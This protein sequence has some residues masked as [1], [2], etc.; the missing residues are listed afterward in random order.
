MFHEKLDFLMK[1]THSSNSTLGKAVSLDASYISRLRNGSRKLP[2]DP[3]F[4]P[5]MVDYFAR[6]ITTEEQKRILATVPTFPYHYEDDSNHLNQLLSHWLLQDTDDMEE[7]VETFLRR[8][9]LLRH[10]AD[11]AAPKLRPALSRSKANYYFG[12]KGKQEAVLRFLHQVTREKFTQTLLLFSSEDMSWLTNDPLFTKQWADLMTT[13]I[14]KGNHIRIIHT[15]SRALNEIFEA[16]TQWLPLYLT[17]SIEPYY[18]PRSQDGVLRR[19]LFI[20]PRTAAIVASS[21]QNNLDDMTNFYITN[22]TLIRAFEKEFERYFAL[23][24]PLMK[25]YTNEQTPALHEALLDFDAKPCNTLLYSPYLSLLTLPSAAAKS[26][27]ERSGQP[28]ILAIQRERET[29]LLENL[30]HFGVIDFLSL[31]NLNTV[32][33]GSLPL[34]LRELFGLPYFYY[35]KEEFRL[36]L[37]NVIDL[38]R[39]EPNYHVVIH[40]QNMTP[41]LLYVKEDY[42]VMLSKVTNPVAVFLIEDNGMTIA[43]WNFLY[44]QT[45][46]TIKTNRQQIIHLLEQYLH[47][48]H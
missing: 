29:S 46:K 15:V 41:Y 35:T 20:A 48:L 36:H 14:L 33:Q 43:F 9:S 34:L 17:G 26:I 40:Q 7:P 5:A 24:K 4:I 16:I 38:L 22:Q 25:I 11:P 2:K 37:A 45:K 39:G 10:Q 3:V 28:A 1:L 27:A 32:L 44:R 6:N 18:Y 12:I 19:T 13:A 8:F 23:C 47:A 21:V 31:P 30:K 42:G